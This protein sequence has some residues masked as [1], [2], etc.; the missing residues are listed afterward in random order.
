[1]ATVKLK[2]FEDY[3]R[4]LRE[5]QDESEDIIKSGVYEG[6]KAV[7]DAVRTQ[8]SGIRTEGPSKYETER[9]EIQK[10]ALKDSLG[11]T[12]MRNDNG[13]INVKIGFDGYNDLKSARWPQG[14]PNAMVAR[15]FESGTSFSSKQPFFKRA[16]NQSKR[17]AAEKM[18]MTIDER[19]HAIE[20]GR[21]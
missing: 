14:Q 8:I 2:G 5:L 17:L 4:I 13:F 7:A 9:R 10:Q 6:S 18:K 19:I 11:I 12:T 20:R 15:I 16:L 3:E 1:M 21:R